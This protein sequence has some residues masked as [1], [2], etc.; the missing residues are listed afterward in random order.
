M[1]QRKFPIIPVTCVVVLIGAFA[2]INARVSKIASMSPQE[3]MNEEMKSQMASRPQPTSTAPVPSKEQVAGA[4]KPSAAGAPEGAPGRGGPGGPGSDAP[5][6]LIP[7]R[8]AYKPT[9]N[10]S[11]TSSQWFNRR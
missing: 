2:V 10:E 6:I 1:K 8:K 9:P 7:E 11:A 4:M 3:Q 5:A